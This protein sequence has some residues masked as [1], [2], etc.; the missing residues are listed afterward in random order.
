[1][2][3]PQL[4]STR[5]LA[6]KV[7][8]LPTPTPGAIRV[9]RPPCRS[10]ED[11]YDT[12]WCNGREECLPSSPRADERGCVSLEPPCSGRECVEEESRCITL[13]DQPWD[14]D[15]DSFG[16]AYC[17]GG[18]DCDDNDGNTFPL[19]LEVCDAEGHDEDCDTGTYGRRDLDGDSE[20]DIRCF[21]RS[22]D[23]TIHH[24]TD[25][26]D[27]NYAVHRGAMI[28]DG[29]DAVVIIN[30][31]PSVAPG[32]R[33]WRP[34]VLPCPTG[35]KCVVQPNR[36]GIC[37]VPPTDYVTPGRFV[38]PPLQPLPLLRTL[39]AQR[40]PALFRSRVNVPSLS[41][42][43]SKPGE[44][45]TTTIPAGGSAEEVAVC[46]RILQSGKVSWGGGTT[47]SS[48]NI[49]KLCSGTKNAKDTIACFQANVGA[50]G[51]S[52]AIDR[53]K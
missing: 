35:T 6:T 33:N 16:S 3:T 23:G 13:C 19:N 1:M 47:W 51:W 5:L 40:N 39:L 20:D 53:C 4:A 7:A 21:N 27:T 14:Q 18:T 34:E 10:N 15:G 45:P 11:C 42:Q 46:K 36:T 12:R 41:R 30:V 8:A 22:A 37:I 2:L 48:T 29:P 44:K 24:G 31:P 43:P 50:L 32:S 38:V 52:A 25:Y 28:C 49:D 9:T 26:D 17:E